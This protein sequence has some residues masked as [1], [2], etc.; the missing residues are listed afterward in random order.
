MMGFVPF[1]RRQT[2]ELAHSPSP[3]SEGMA[4]MHLQA[5]KS[6]LIKFKD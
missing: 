4:R 1:T 5:R 3:S 2:S 6:T